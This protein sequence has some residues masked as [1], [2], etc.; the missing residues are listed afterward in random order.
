MVNDALIERAARGETRA[1]YELYRAL[2]PLMLG[3]CS[4]YERN[5]QDAVAALNEAYLKVLRG[6][7]DRPAH[8]PFEPWLRRI[9]I[10]TVIDAWRREKQRKTME[11]L[12]GEMNE[13]HAADANDYLR[14]METEA[15]AHLVAQ[16]PDATR[17]V[18]NLFAIDGHAHAE[19]AELLGISAG[20]SK[21]HVNHARTLLRR[22]LLAQQRPIPT[23]I[24]HR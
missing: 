12:P 13:D 19:I 17:H 2:H 23:F 16:L 1:Q 9:T 24:Q 5:R 15:F 21:W 3:I 20:T 14:E 22:A 7:K 11:A 10:N 18:F 8:V 6:L 4:R